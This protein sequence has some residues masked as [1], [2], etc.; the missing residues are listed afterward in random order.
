MTVPTPD[1]AV[2][3]ATAGVDDVAVATARRI[4]PVR[5]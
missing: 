2:V 4:R 3:A 1:T 5:S